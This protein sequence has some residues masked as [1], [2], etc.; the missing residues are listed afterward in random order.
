MVLLY[1]IELVLLFVICFSFFSL[2]F[3]FF[4]LM[5][6]VVFS[7]FLFWSKFLF[8]CANV[9]VHHPN[10]LYFLVTGFIQSLRVLESPWGLKAPFQGLGKSSKICNKKNKK[11]TKHITLKSLKIET[12][13]LEQSVL[14]NIV[15]LFHPAV[16]NIQVIEWYDCFWHSITV[17]VLF[18]SLA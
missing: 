14:T 6:L 1:G 3:F 9:L 18:L 10:P 12:E 2:F 4:F 17:P 8:S 11:T 7:C 15:P 5:F 13:Y 16:F